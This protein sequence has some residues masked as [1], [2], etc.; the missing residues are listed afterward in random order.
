M[1]IIRKK[2]LWSCV[3]LSAILTNLHSCLPLCQHKYEIQRNK[4]NML[5][6]NMKAI[7]ASWTKGKISF[8]VCLPGLRSAQVREVHTACAAGREALGDWHLD[9]WLLVQETT[10]REAAWT[11]SPRCWWGGD[12]PLHLSCLH[13]TPLTFKY[14]SESV[15]LQRLLCDSVIMGCISGGQEGE[16]RGLVSA[17]VERCGSSH[18]AC[19]IKELERRPVSIRD[20]NMAVPGGTPKWQTGLVQKKTKHWETVQKEPER[21]ILFE[22]AEII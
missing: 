21:P 1:D 13:F 7:K 22:Q 10:V 8:I 9:Y 20:M 4:L 2:P 12:C 17:F 18:L 14:N 15:H 11:V 3:L 5:I 19:K 16:Y 6:N